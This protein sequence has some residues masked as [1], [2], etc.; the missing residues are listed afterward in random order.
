M[1]TAQSGFKLNKEQKEIQTAAPEFS[2]G[3]FPD[4]AQ[5]FDR[6]EK[7]DLDIWK[8]ACELGLVDVF[9]KKKYEG[10]K[11]IEKGIIPKSLLG[12]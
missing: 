5:E 3:E 11:E 1:V 8:K 6:E 7:F 10:V 4:R 9:I 12:L 2:L